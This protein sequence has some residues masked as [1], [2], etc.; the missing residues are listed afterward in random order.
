MKL[1]PGKCHFIHKEVEYFSYIIIPRGLLLND[2]LVAAV[3]EYVQ[4]KN[5]QELRRF[6]GLASYHK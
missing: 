3:K 2:K 5:V 6:L 1:N 4:P